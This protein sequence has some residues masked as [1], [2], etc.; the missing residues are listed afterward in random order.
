MVTDT[1]GAGSGSGAGLRGHKILVTGPAGQIA[2]DLC[3]HLAQHNDVWGV[4]RFSVPASRQQC[5]DIGVRTVVADLGEDS[6]DALPADFDYVLHLAAYQ[7]PGLDYDAAIRSNAEATGLLMQHCRQARAILVM[8]THSVYAPH[9]D[10]LH[11]FHETDPLGDVK[12]AHAPT[13]SVSK[14]MQ[15]GVARACA[16]TFGVP[17]VIARMNASYGPSG[18][19]PVLHLQALAAGGT[20]TTRWDPCPYMPIHADDIAAHTA[21]LLAVASSPATVVN[22]AGDEV[23]SPQDWVPYLAGLLG[24]EPRL[25]VVE[26]PGTLRGSIADNSRRLAAAGPCTVPWRDGLRRCVEQ[27]QA[28]RE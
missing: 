8:S 10:P 26:T 15:E 13:Y 7:A 11:V 17:T 19:L 5:E 27:F 18:G 1:T 20:V 3:A 24:V 14:L 28:G 25:Q 22:W 2:F 4:A 12:P 9:A 6:L 23:V 16:R 21:G